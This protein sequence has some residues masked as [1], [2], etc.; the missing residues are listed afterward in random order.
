MFER[1]KHALVAGLALLGVAVA[2]TSV[3]AADRTDSVVQTIDDH[4]LSWMV[5]VRTPWLTTAAKAM[6]VIGGPLVMVP[7]RLAIIGALV[8]TRRWLQLVAFVA[9]I[10]T[11]EL[12]IGPL[13]ALI[14]RPR[15]PDA[16]IETSSSSFPSG[17]AIA[18]SVT[19]IGLVVVLV[20]AAN[21]RLRWTVV[22]ATFRGSDGDESHVP[23]R[24]LAERRDRRGLFR[25]GPRRR[26]VRRLR[27]RQGTASRTLAGAEHG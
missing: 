15:P 20:P 26:L 23:R 17:H 24:P 5:D 18:A 4:W 21:R 27:A 8:W 11:S 9:A 12:C 3:V 13:K 10:I 6:S 25:Y 22:A 2:L 16:L 19:A 1:R 14:D 7:V